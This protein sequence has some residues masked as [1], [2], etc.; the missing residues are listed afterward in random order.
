[1]DSLDA[2]WENMNVSQQIFSIDKKT[3]KVGDYIA[4]KGYNGVQKFKIDS[5]T[6]G[7][8][9]IST[10][11]KDES[12]VKTY[13][14]VNELKKNV[15]LLSDIKHMEIKYINYMS[16]LPFEKIL[17]MKHIIE[18]MDSNI[19]LSADSL[20]IGTLM[21]KL[22]CEIKERVMLYSC[23]LNK[24]DYM[25]YTC[26]A[27]K[28]SSIYRDNLELISNK[29]KFTSLLKE[30][31]I[32]HIE[33]MEGLILGEVYNNPNNFIFK[34]SR[35]KEHKFSY[36]AIYSML[37]KEE[38]DNDSKNDNTDECS[39]EEIRVYSKE[40]SNCVN[41]LDDFE[42]QIA[43]KD[44]IV[45]EV[46][47]SVEEVD[48]V[49]LIENT[50]EDNSTDVIQKT[51][52]KTNKEELF[53]TIAQYIYDEN[54]SYFDSAIFSKKNTIKQYIDMFI[55]N[56]DTFKNALVG[57]GKI[58]MDDTKK[59]LFFSV[60]G[61]DEFKISLNSFINKLKKK[62]ESKVEQFSFFDLI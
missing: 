61:S 54:K 15:W 22:D 35:G 11:Y 44:I 10:L 24:T 38:L 4:M 33:K 25:M 50:V 16:E 14:S 45:D 8:I 57:E 43:N 2:I 29:N 53:E 9:V 32:S 20:Y 48:I 60:K 19:D 55:N 12:I 56:K 47:T 30:A 18:N 1:M 5:I 28:R 26:E 49:D 52:S 62:Q 31:N 34:D 13:P 6:P 46:E 23:L 40:L 7:A 39:F 21:D 17:D 42:S 36:N 51:N 41:E 3:Y 37:T 58:H 59:Y 27:I